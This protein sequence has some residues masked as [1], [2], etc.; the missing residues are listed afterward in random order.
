[1]D[2][3]PSLKV[4]FF[5]TCQVRVVRFYQSCSSPPPPR[6]ALLFL[7]LVLLRLLVRLLPLL[8]HFH[9]HCCLANSSPSSSEL[10]VHR[11]TSTWDLPSSVC[12]AGPQPGTCPAQWAPL[13]LNLGPAQLSVHR[14]TSTWDLPS[15]VCTAGPQPGTC[16]A[17]WAPLD[18]N[19]GPAQLSVHRWTSTWDLPSS[20][21]TAGPQPGTCPAQRAPLDLNGQIE[22]QKICQIKCQK[23]CQIECQKICQIEC[24]K[25]CQIQCQKICQI[26]PDRMPDRMP[27]DMSDRMPEDMPDRMSE[28][29]P[30]TKRINVMVGITRSKVISCIFPGSPVPNL[31]VLGPVYFISTHPFK[32]KCPTTGQQFRHTVHG[33]AGSFEH[34]YVKSQDIMTHDCLRHFSPPAR[35]VLLDFI[36]AVVLR[37]QFLRDHVCINFHLHFRLA[38]SSPSASPTSELSAHCWTSTWDLPSSVRTAGPQPGTFPAQCAPLDLN[39]GPSQLSAHRWTST[40]DLP[41]SVRTAGPQPG[42]FRAQCA[43]LGRWT[44]TWDLPS[45]VRTGGPQLPDRMPE[46]MPD[47]MSDRMPEDMPDK[48]P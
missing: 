10:S 30:V 28:G 38:N 31:K 32:Y 21:C 12:T 17:Q 15:S 47:R 41:S 25:I 22:C 4:D 1:M 16:P 40:W 9:V 29:L 33:G 27:E 43:P 24:Q 36:R 35:W 3:S 34:V 42:T 46:D 39:L 44:S 18:L 45:S 37:L 14:W 19:L 2:R 26:D 23:I 6:L 48:T 5:P 11:W 20:V 13:D 8:F 7:L